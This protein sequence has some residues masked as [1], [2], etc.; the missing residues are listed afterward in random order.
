MYKTDRSR[1]GKFIEE[2]ENDELQGKD[3]FLK[4]V[5]DACRILAGWR[6]RYGNKETI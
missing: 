5:S 1:Y 4:T 2:M 3:P 6:N